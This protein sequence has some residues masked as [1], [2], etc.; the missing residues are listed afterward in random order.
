MRSLF[1]L[2]FF[3]ALSL[4]AAE[5]LEPGGWQ[6]QYRAA[7]DKPR[8]LELV[9]TP[10]DQALEFI[11]SVLRIN[12]YLDPRLQDEIPSITIRATDK[13][14]FSAAF[15]AL[16]EKHGLAYELRDDALLVLP[17]AAASAKKLRDAE[18]EKD[19]LQQAI[20]DLSA[21]QAARREKAEAAILEFGPG[22]LK[23][24]EALAQSSRD[25]EAKLR[26]RRLLPKL[27]ATPIAGEA[28]EVA[29]E[30]DRLEETLTREF[31]DLSVQDVLI[32]IDAQLESYDKPPVRGR[33]SERNG[34]KLKRVSFSVRKM[35]TGNVLRWLAR[36]A[37]G[38]IE[39]LDGNLTIVPN[40]SK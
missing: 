3:L 21:D 1:V 34:G 31:F 23:Q 7:L 39:K 24:I 25:P 37:G 36:Y 17:K 32:E 40:V 18:A 12:C 19:V 27:R 20:A 26:A 10:L 11:G 16:L 22:A 15:N 35:Q 9:E 29:E 13:G 28:P 2:A 4:R 8:V 38:R 14:K 30:L 5:E 6:D 33:F